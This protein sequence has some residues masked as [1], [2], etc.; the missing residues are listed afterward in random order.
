LPR[1]AA[2]ALRAG[3]FERRQ[4]CRDG[5]IAVWEAAFDLGESGQPRRLAIT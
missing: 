5:R 2:L 3:A 1:A 4:T